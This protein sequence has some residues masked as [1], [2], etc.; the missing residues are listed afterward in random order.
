[1]RGGRESLGGQRVV[2]DQ[3]RIAAE[4][5]RLALRVQRARLPN[6]GHG[7]RGVGVAGRNH[8]VFADDDRGFMPVGF[9]R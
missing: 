8:G 9:A 6:G 5:C 3:S 1:M 7:Q 4:G 2:D